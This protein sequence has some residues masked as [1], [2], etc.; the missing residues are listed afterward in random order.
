L[1]FPLFFLSSRQKSHPLPL[2]ICFNFPP[3][4]SLI[5]PDFSAR[6]AAF[7][8]SLL[9]LSSL[10]FSPQVF[11]FLAF[12]FFSVFF[13]PGF[14]LLS[15]FF[16]LCFFL[17]SFFSSQPHAS[18]FLLNFFFLLFQLFFSSQLFFFFF[19]SFFFFFLLSFFF[20]SQL[21]FSSLR[22]SLLQKPSPLFTSLALR[23]SQIHKTRRKTCFTVFVIME[24]QK[25]NSLLENLKEE[26]PG[27]GGMN[28]QIPSTR[29]A[30]RLARK[31]SE[32][33]TYLVVALMSSLGITSMAVMAV[34]YRFSWQMEV[35]SLPLSLKAY[36]SLCTYV[37]VMEIGF[38]S[39]I[40]WRGALV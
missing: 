4:F 13:S 16:L 30:E 28:S 34:Y 7:F 6:H 3:L 27:P 5:P 31:R 10:F 36:R 21:F 24:D 14:F 22:H 40:G 38:C 32:R 25:R 17:P 1:L 18:F 33:F 20:S 15:F 39:G 26:D 19:L 9:F 11:F 2:F 23:H 35:L 8:S 29:A 12:F 37:Y